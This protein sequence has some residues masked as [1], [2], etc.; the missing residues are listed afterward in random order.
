M[1]H[2]I[3][4]ISVIVYAGFVLFMISGLFKHAELDVRSYDILPNVSVVIAARN[5]EVHISNL[6]SDL[7]A[8]E[9]PL[10][11]LEVIIVNDRS[12]DMTLSILN[13]ASDNYAFIKVISIDEPSKEM[14]P[15]KNALSKGI[16]SAVGEIIVLTD[17]DCRVGRLWVSSMAYSVM[18]QNSITIGFSEI[19]SESDSLFNRYQKI[20]FL[21]IVIANAGFSG[22]GFFWSGTG[23]NL[24][25]YKSDFEKIGGFEKVKNRISGDDM[26]LVQ[27]ISKIKTGCIQIDPNSFVKTSPMSS[28]HSFFDQRVRWSS[29]AKLNFYDEPLFFSFLLVTLSYNLLIL[30]SFLFGSSWVGL[31]SFKLMLDGITIF[32]GGKLFNRKMDIIAYCLWAILQP[33]YIPVIGIWGIRG[34]FNWKP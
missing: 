1:I 25:F 7:I 32:L 27:S 31:I 29:N 9:Y 12:T 16:E 18:N 3:T 17:A 19:N 4:Y 2:L 34:K 21:S 22:W 24:A 20:D 10:D 5:E 8:Q 6:I 13:E 14:T 26:Y 23:Q 33:I 30:I 15:K 28:L 11:K